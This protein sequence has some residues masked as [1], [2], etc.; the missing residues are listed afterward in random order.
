MKRSAG[1]LI[2]EKHGR[3]L[4]LLRLDGLWDLPGG[5]AEPIDCDALDTALRELSEETGYRGPVYLRGAP[6]KTSRCGDRIRMG[7]VRGADVHY[8]AYVGEAL[9]I[10]NPRLDG[11]HLDAVWVRPERAPQPLLP[12]TRTVLRWA[13]RLELV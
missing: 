1:V 13:R 11:E 9:S 6:L 10:F 4:L 8:T 5:G 12:G 7:H 2:T 3:C